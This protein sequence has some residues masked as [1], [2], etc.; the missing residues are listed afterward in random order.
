MILCMLIMVVGFKVVLVDYKS[1]MELLN[2][3]SLHHRMARNPYKLQLQEA[4]VRLLR[5]FFP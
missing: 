4:I 2:D 1:Y 5:S 3:F